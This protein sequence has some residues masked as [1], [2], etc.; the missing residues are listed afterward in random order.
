MLRIVFHPK[1]RMQKFLSSCVHALHN[2]VK[3]SRRKTLRP[4][5]IIVIKIRFSHR[6]SKVR[7]K[8]KNL[9]VIRFQHPCQFLIVFGVA[10]KHIRRNA[11]ALFFGKFHDFFGISNPILRVRNKFMNRLFR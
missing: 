9:A 5:F 3:K 8:C 6:L 11:I 4:D 1:N 2:R 7:T 10:V